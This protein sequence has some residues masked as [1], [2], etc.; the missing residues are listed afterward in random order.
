MKK[1]RQ[2]LNQRACSMLGHCGGR[3]VD[4]AAF[5]Q[6]STMKLTRH[7][8]NLPRSHNSVSTY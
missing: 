3:T 4:T 7:L 6:R 5:D 2:L 8:A 1:A